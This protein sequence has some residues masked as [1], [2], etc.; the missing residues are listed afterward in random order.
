M[1][2]E[3]HP[4]ARLGLPSLAFATPCLSSLKGEFGDIP[5]CLMDRRSAHRPG[6]T[7]FRT[8]SQECLVVNLKKLRETFCGLNHKVESGLFGCTREGFRVFSKFRSTP[9][10]GDR[11]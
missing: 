3:D 7:G 10:S 11:E 8:R 6:H 2:D 5:A 9:A 4:S 1:G